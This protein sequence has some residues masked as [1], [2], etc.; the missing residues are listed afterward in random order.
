MYSLGI[1]P[2]CVGER[3]CSLKNLN[4]LN[5]F[6]YYCMRSPKACVFVYMKFGADA[7][8]Q[9]IKVYKTAIENFIKARPREVSVVP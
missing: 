2:Q 1:Y 6:L 3:S 5:L 9:M 8:F 4:C 7:P